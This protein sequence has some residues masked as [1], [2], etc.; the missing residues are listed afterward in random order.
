MT[1]LRGHSSLLIADYILY[2]YG[3]K[4]TPFQLIKLVFISHGRTLAVLD[5]PLIRDRIE[6]WKYGPV[7]PL[8][9]HQLKIWGE[10]R[11]LELNY[12]GTVPNM[13][14]DIDA[15]RKAFFEST[16]PKRERDIIDAAVR[17]YE[18]WSLSDLQKLCHEVGSP[19]DKHYDGKFGTEI[20]DYAIR[21]YYR[22]EMIVCNSKV[23]TRFLE[24]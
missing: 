16:I 3:C 20:P 9:H 2:E 21:E 23:T 10:A 5:K 4:F 8:L 17:D 12:C 7:I 1:V 22:N 18:D 14:T 19:W 15:N 11:V 13:D 6:A 24:V